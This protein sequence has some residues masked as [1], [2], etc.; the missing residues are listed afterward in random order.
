MAYLRQSDYARPRDLARRI[1]RH[2]R[3]SISH[4]WGFTHLGSFADAHKKMYGENT[5][6]SLR[7][8]RTRTPAGC[9][10][11]RA[12]RKDLAR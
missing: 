4:S 7:G 5:A 10:P 1:P 9:V 12:K 3:A 11:L 8:A 2:H 6:A